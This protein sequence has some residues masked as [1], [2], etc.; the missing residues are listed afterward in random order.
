MCVSVFSAKSLSGDRLSHLITIE[1]YCFA[2]QSLYRASQ[3]GL[4]ALTLSCKPNN[5]VGGSG[6]FTLLFSRHVMDVFAELNSSDS[7]TYVAA[8]THF[9]DIWNDNNAYEAAPFLK[10]VLNPGPSLRGGIWIVGTRFGI[11]DRDHN[12]LPFH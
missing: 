12:R 4:P 1:D 5:R 7:I 2:E 8:I 11:A 3:C 9:I 10:A 6:H